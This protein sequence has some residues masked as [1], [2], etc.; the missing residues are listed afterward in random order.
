MV[1]NG[2]WFK[3]FSY[4]VKKSLPCCFKGK[5]R[6]RVP[7]IW[8]IVYMNKGILIFVITVWSEWQQ[9]FSTTNVAEC[10]TKSYDRFVGIQRAPKMEAFFSTARSRYILEHFHFPGAL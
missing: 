2:A 9:I 8:F 4:Y 7:H 6:Q 10:E 3:G 5:R 1:K